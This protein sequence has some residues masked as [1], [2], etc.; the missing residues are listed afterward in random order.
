MTLYGH[1]EKGVVVFEQ[2]VALPDGTKVKVEPVE[3][4]PAPPSETEIPSLYDRLQ[5]FI[6][7]AQG[8]PEDASRNVDH[9]RAAP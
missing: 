3:K 9:Y 2:Q 1:I 7:A 5:P 8:L 4:E 6:G